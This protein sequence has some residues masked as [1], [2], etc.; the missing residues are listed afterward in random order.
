LDVMDAMAADLGADTFVRHSRAL[1]RRPDAQKV[2]RT[3]RAPALVLC[4]G[5][6]RLTPV[7]RHTF[8]A[9]MIPHAELAIIEEAGHLLTLE[10]PEKVNLA[11]RA[12]MDLPMVLR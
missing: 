10:A 5:H 12:W 2:L 9:E 7:K 4:G 3:I 8:M 1:Q 11:L 6:D